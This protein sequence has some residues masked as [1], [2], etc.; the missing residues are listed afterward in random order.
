MFVAWRRSVLSC[1]YI[2]DFSTSNDETP[3]SN[4]RNEAG[5]V[6][7]RTGCGIFFSLTPHQWWVFWPLI[8]D[9]PA[10][11]LCAQVWF[12]SLFSKT[13][14]KLTDHSNFLSFDCHYKL[15]VK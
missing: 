10:F 15:L 8:V 3:H 13:L 1:I 6:Y 9:N 4:H 7:E 2:T 11:L 5:F 14:N 12:L